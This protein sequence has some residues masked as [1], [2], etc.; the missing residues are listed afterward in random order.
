MYIVYTQP[1]VVI[2]MKRHMSQ[3]LNNNI[4]YTKSSGLFGVH[5]ELY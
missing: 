2:V 1:Y 3:K 4:K 5:L